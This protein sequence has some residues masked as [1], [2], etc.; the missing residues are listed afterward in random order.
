M[1]ESD[2]K[3]ACHNTVA[4]DGTILDNEKPAPRAFLEWMAKR[5][6]GVQVPAEAAEWPLRDVNLFYLSGGAIRPDRP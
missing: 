3:I 4:A 1:K 6:P 5:S 2:F